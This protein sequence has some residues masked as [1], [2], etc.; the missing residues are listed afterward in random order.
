M[1]I[2]QALLL[3]AVAAML[4]IGA[5]AAG[6]RQ[7]KA[8]PGDQATSC[9]AYG[10]GFHY[11][12]AADA[13]VKVGGWVRAQAGSGHGAVNWG[14]LNAGPSAG[15]SGTGTTAV[16][17][18]ATLTTDVRKQTGYGTVRGYLSVGADHE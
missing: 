16:G 7:I 17:A 8:K 6:E 1:K 9:S 3:G 11:V 15:A 14:A 13:C 10:P 5:A 12:P 18:R 4:A 2:L